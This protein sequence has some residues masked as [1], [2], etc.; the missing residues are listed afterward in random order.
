IVGAKLGLF[1]KLTINAVLVVILLSLIVTP[2]LVT[3]FGKKITKE[4]AEAEALGS[5][6][7]V[8]IWGEST[9]AVLA[10]AAR[11]AQPDS[12]IVLA[13]SIAREDDTEAQLTSQRSLR[14]KA[15]QWLA[16]LGLEAR[17]IFRVSRSMAAGLLQTV[18]SDKASLLLSEWHFEGLDP[19]SEASQ[20]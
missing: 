5:A 13:A 4:E 18:R 12:G 7:L 14:D 6:V 10:I 8:P 20:L 3:Y 2:A 1:D 19:H 16:K 17:S 15:E 11:L 9:R